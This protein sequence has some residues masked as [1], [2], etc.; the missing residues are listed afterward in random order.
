MAQPKQS[1]VVIEDDDY[2]LE[3]TAEQ[4]K[5]AKQRFEAKEDIGP[6]KY[7]WGGYPNKKPKQWWIEQID[8]CYGN[9]ERGLFGSDHSEQVHNLTFY[10][11]WLTFYYAKPNLD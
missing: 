6:K 1:K 11:L 9:L 10:R 7:Y 4:W 3:F 5:L 2:Y 8:I